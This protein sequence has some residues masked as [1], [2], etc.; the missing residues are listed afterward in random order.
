M[1]AY[2]TVELPNEEQCPNCGAAVR[3]RVQFKYGDTWQH[4]YDVGDVIRWG[5]NDI[6]APGRLVRVLGYVESCPTCKADVDRNVEMTVRDGRI[7]S[8]RDGSTA[9]YIAAGHVT[10]LIDEG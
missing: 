1:S 8:F 9:E 2:N 10:F 6:G 7:E 4:H 5:G 3:R